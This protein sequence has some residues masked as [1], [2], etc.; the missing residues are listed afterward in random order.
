MVERSDPQELRDLVER[1]GVSPT[2][3][4]KSASKNELTPTKSCLPSSSNV[5]PS[6]SPGLGFLYVLHPFYPHTHSPIHPPIHP[7]IHPST[8]PSFPPIHPSIYS[9][10]N[11]SL[12][13]NNVPGTVLGTGA[14]KTHSGSGHA[15]K[16][17]V[18]RICAVFTGQV[19]REPKEGCGYLSGR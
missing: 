12:S 19:Q 3:M 17:T 1:L 18:H 10:N 2:L 9:I 6:E 11:Y 4:V 16:I 13:P 15:N 8:C 5:G 7:S 14:Q